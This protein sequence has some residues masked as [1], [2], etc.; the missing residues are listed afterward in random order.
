MKSSKKRNT[1]KNCYW[2][3]GREK[4]EGRSPGPRGPDSVPAYYMRVLE[5]SVRREYW[6]F[7]TNTKP[8]VNTELG[9]PSP[10]KGSDGSYT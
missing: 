6:C 2:G 3:A 5:V 10:L 4:E 7:A 8:S 1:N 9:N